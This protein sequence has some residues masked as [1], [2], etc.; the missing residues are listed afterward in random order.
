MT[1][2]DRATALVVKGWRDG[3]PRTAH[4]RYD[5]AI[6]DH[7]APAITRGLRALWPTTA[8]TATITTLRHLTTSK[9]GEG[10]AA[11]RA[12]RA[13]LSAAARAALSSTPPDTEALATA[14]AGL[15][16]DAWMTGTHVAAGQTGGYPATPTGSLSAGLDWAAWEPGYV[17]AAA[18][19]A[20]GQLAAQLAA[21][22]IT[23][24][25]LT[26]TTTRLVG[27][28][29]ASGLLAGDPTTR[30]R[31]AITAITGDPNR[32]LLIAHTETAR[33]MTE[34][35]FDTYRA[36]GIQW[37]DWLTTSGA[38]KTCRDLEDANPHALGEPGPPAHPLCRCSAAP[39]LST[40]GWTTPQ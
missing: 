18:Y 23:L 4:G 20:G 34:A 33:A 15:T 9:A 5:L 39:T 31:A 40:H 10:D 1:A 38:C 8:L 25:G 14:L 36:N 29:I 21:V 24:T 16:V 37:W 13:A 6:T 12:A 32:A 26:H 3:M 35:T 30:I 2:D 17:E 11:A 27:D 28:A 19:T 7:Y 22:N